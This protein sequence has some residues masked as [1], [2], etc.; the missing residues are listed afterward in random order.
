ML[1]AEKIGIYNYCY[2][3]AYLFGIFSLLGLENYG[4]RSIARIPKDDLAQRSSTFF[5]I[6]KM[7]LFSSLLVVGLYIVYFQVYGKEYKVFFALELLYLLS[8]G[9]DISWFFFGIE[10]FRTTAIR[11][12]I[13][14][15][16][17]IIFIVTFVRGKAALVI[18]II[19]MA[20]GS[21]CSSLVLWF[22]LRGKIVKIKVPLSEV[23]KHILPNIILFIPVVSLALFHYMDKVMLGSLSTMAELGYYSNA[24]KVI[25]IPLG[26]IH[27]L[28]VVMLPRISSLVEAGESATIKRL[29]SNSIVFCMWA[30]SAICFGIIGLAKDFVPFF[31]GPGYDKCIQILAIFAPVVIIKAW[32]SVFR[33]QY[34]LPHGMD[35]E[36]NISL[37]LAALIN[38]LFNWFAIPFLNS[39]GAVIG[40]LIAEFVAAFLYTFF[41]KQS[42]IVIEGF[43]SAIRFLLIGILMLVCIRISARI[44]V[45]LNIILRLAIEFVVGT[46][47][48]L[49]LSG[50]ILKKIYNYPITK[51]I[52]EL[53]KT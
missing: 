42:D 15:L 8:V 17:T 36:F 40:T 52:R 27:G 50:L 4:N 39:L 28:G 53:K 47:V 38:I 1:G 21:F 44:A 34:L 23:K 10:E 24:D 46:T 20:G 19:I 13:I 11:S 6:V 41:S 25:N 7:Q 51:A 18:Y 22:F 5:S 16:L 33:M 12:G 35:K 37:I 31:F 29:I 32:S 9:L 26:V 2:S 48:Y 43:V 45:N 30:G 3:T 14:K 49:L